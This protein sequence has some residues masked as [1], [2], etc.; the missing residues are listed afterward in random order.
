MT[1]F[2][3]ILN[4]RNTNI[5][6][7]AKITG[8]ANNAQRLR[9]YLKQEVP[10][11]NLTYREMM[12]FCDYLNCEPSDLLEDFEGNGITTANNVNIK[13]LA[14]R[15]I[16][17]IPEIFEDVYFGTFRIH[18]KEQLLWI[19]YTENYVDFNLFSVHDDG[20]YT[21]YRAIANERKGYLDAEFYRYVS[22]DRMFT[23]NDKEEDL[24]QLGELK[25]DNQ[26]NLID[27]KNYIDNFKME[28]QGEPISYKEFFNYLDP[29]Q[30]RVRD[31]N[32]LKR[33]KEEKK[34][35]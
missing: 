12:L 25:K 26:E 6:D 2:E 32:Y 8:S 1:K 27:F 7:L 4:E 22:E 15:M 34:K 23:Y 29:I 35:K 33:K 24:I 3:N 20:T 10:L 21:L 31:S 9:K 11:S 19:T 17:Q 14:K 30:I 16:K 5:T 13:N 18:E 28:I